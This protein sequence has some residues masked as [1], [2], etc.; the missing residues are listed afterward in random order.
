MPVQDTD[1]GTPVQELRQVE[2]ATEDNVGGDTE[3]DRKRKE[4]VRN[5]GNV[6]GRAVHWSGPGLPENDEG[7]GEGGAAG[8]A[9]RTNRGEGGGRYMVSLGPLNCPFLLALF[10][11]TVTLFFSLSLFLS[12]SSL[13]EGQAGRGQGE[14]PRAAGGLLEGAAD[15]ERERTVYNIVMIQ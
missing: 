8:A 6:C 3:K 13:F 4:P 7:G 11:S 9:T 10:L 1:K 15:G 5:Q 12:F 2:A 14:S